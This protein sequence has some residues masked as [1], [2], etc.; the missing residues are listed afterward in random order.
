MALGPLM[1]PGTW[2][3]RMTVASGPFTLR[4]LRALSTVTRFVIMLD[5]I[6]L[7]P[8]A[9]TPLVTST[10]SPADAA[11][12]ATWMTVAAVAQFV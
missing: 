8:V 11:S 2:Y 3:P 10:V 5:P 9:Y 6:G 12:T 7:P 1:V 4:K